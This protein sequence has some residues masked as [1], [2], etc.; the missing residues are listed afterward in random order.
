VIIRGCATYFWKFFDKG[1]NFA[2][3]FAS[4]RGMQKKLRASNVAG[5]PILRILGLP[6]W[7]CWEKHH[8]GVTS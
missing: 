5:V 2:L 7:E 1:Y 8:L 3:D 6:T 4:I